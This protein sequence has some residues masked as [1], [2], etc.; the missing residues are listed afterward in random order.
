MAND[1]VELFKRSYQNLLQ[2]DLSRLDD[3]YTREVVFKDPV[4]EVRGL[5]M[6]QDYMAEICRNVTECRFEFLDQLQSDHAAYI[7]WDMHYCHPRLAAGKRITLRGV[8]QIQF[9]ERVYFHED[10]YD[11]GSMLYEHL[12]LM[13]GVTRWLKARLAKS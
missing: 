6:L 9:D 11:M 1:T 8:S 7:K 3:L 10:V 12:P 4:H 5:V 2:T 13:G